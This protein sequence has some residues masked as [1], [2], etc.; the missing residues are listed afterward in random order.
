MG[1]QT[2]R[3]RRSLGGGLD[4]T[5]RDLYIDVGE[6]RGLTLCGSIAPLLLARRCLLALPFLAA[7]LFL[8][9]SMLTRL[10]PSLV[11][12]D[13]STI[14]VDSVLFYLAAFSLHSQ[15]LAARVEEDGRQRPNGAEPDNDKRLGGQGSRGVAQAGRGGIAPATPFVPLMRKDEGAPRGRS[16]AGRAK[17]ESP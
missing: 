8:F 4:I 5:C 6:R 1:P 10:F 12:H 17:V 15:V 7:L 11:F 9:F 14:H 16:S 3:A 2:P 13:Q